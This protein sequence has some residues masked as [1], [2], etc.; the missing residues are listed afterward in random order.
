[1]AL[2]VDTGKP[3]R[4]CQ[5]TDIHLGGYPLGVEDQKTLSGLRQIFSENNFDLIMITGDLIL[6]KEN[7]EPL[8]SLRELYDL[9]NEFEI[10]VAI[11]YGN[12][13]TDG[14]YSRKC[15]RDFE[16]NLINLVPHNN[17]F[18]VDD[19]ENYTLE[20]FDRK[21][22]KLVNV[23]YIWDGGDYS[24][25]AEISRYAVID[26]HQINWYVKTTKN[27][28]RRT[29]DLGFMHIPLPEYKEIDKS[30]VDGIY[31]DEVHCAGINSGLFYELLNI[32]RVKAIFVGHDHN[33][34]FSA[35][36]SGIGL[37][38]GNVTGYN[39]KSKVNCGVS[40][41]SLYKDHVIK[42]VIKFKN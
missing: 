3:F 9:L 5:L 22:D 23:L 29:F 30:K 40:E 34:N 19:K 20:V 18:L 33:N 25:Y 24:Q 16:Q 36:F 31:Q 39:A 38:Y 12:N 1:M 32:G 14:I 13:D 7:N 28:F 35:D 6:G 2:Y 15:L 8:E 11:T 21:T 10:P 17:S 27:Y 41:I 26:R 37:N 42:K 4:I